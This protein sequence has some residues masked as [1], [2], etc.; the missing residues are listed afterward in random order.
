VSRRR[1]DLLLLCGRSDLRSRIEDS[2]LGENYRINLASTAAEG[3]ET[4]GRQRCHLAIVDIASLQDPED[5]KQIRSALPLTS[6]VITVGG[7]D[8]DSV[9]ALLRDGV[10][11]AFPDPLDSLQFQQV[12]RNAVER[13]GL[14]E[15]NASLRNE[16]R[17]SKSLIMKDDLT[18]AYNRRYFD[19][20]L[21][22]EIERS[23]RF[24]SPLSLIFM[25]LDDLKKVNNRYGHAMGSL[26]LK[27]AAVRIID[28]VRSIDKAIRYG[29][30][31][32]CIILPETDWRGAQE[33][34]ERIRANFANGLFLVGKTEG[35]SLTASFGIASFPQHAQT[36]GEM[37][38]KADEAMFLIKGK[39]KDGILVAE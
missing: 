9:R 8:D 26:A 32:F 35:V 37:I 28:T 10:Y 4:A 23:K 20:F 19:T 30:D 14:V 29:G 11:H 34:A 6:P 27:E 1:P 21:D 38:K 16:L 2:L 12:V 25:D 24:S 5:V 39:Q 15:E 33:V 7:G 22:E 17:R 36:K 18:S 31:E 3:L 13:T